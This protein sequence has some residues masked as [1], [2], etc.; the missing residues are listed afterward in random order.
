M[1]PK[2]NTHTS[3]FSG[4]TIARVMGACSRMHGPRGGPV[5][6]IAGGITASSFRRALETRHRGKKYC[7][8]ATGRALKDGEHVERPAD[9]AA[10]RRQRGGAARVVRSRAE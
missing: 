2:R 5:V 1:E 8:A 7:Y 10:A 9:G 3:D 6:H 4:R